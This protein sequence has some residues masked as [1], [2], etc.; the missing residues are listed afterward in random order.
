MSDF[1][2]FIRIVKKRRSTKS[3]KPDPIPDEAVR[4]ILEAARWA[5]S[6]A[7]GQPWEFIVVKDQETRRKI[8][9]LHAEAFGI[10]R[11]LELSRTPELMHRGSPVQVPSAFVVAPVHIAI[12][13]DPRTLITSVITVSVLSIER[14]IFH[15]NMA[16][17]A[18]IMHLSATAL[19]LNSQW[20]SVN[21]TWEASLKSLLGVPE[22]YR[23]PMM[24]ILG[25][26]AREP[27]PGIRRNLDDIVHHE[28][29]DMTKYR[30]SETYLKDLAELRKHTSTGKPGA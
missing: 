14:E 19:G 18:M 4:S 2:T 1:D 10:T 22:F 16:N 24:V 12:A 9:T 7:N 29:Y 6:G 26:P 15:H 28:R 27:S 11:P 25:Y 21:P 30:S 3:L 23:V 8:G 13:G 20:I 17:A 5:M